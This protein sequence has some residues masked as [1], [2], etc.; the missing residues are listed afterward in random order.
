MSEREELILNPIPKDEQDQIEKR[1]KYEFD[2][3]GVLTDQRLPIFQSVGLQRFLVCALPIA[4][5]L[6]KAQKKVF[7]S[8]IHHEATQGREIGRASCRERV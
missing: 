1:G 8:Q 7:T 4:G 6:L 3:I 5:E 2:R